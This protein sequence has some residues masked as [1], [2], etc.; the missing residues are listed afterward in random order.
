MARNR[1]IRDR[2]NLGSDATEVHR[3]HGEGRPLESGCAQA[4]LN[5]E[6]DTTNRHGDLRLNR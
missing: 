6:R 4:I 2:Q 3:Q 5:G 1:L